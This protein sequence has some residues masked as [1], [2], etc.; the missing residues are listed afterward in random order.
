[1]IKAHP[2]SLICVHSHVTSYTTL[3]DAC[4]GLYPELWVTSGGDMPTYSWFV[5]H[6][7]KSLDD[8]VGGHS[9]CSGGATALA[10][11]GA[12]DDSIQAMGQWSSNTFQIYIRKHP[13][14]LYALIHNKPAF[15]PTSPS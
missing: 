12:N 2:S 9:L 15:G 3:C 1:M 5:S 13:V 8:E 10:L 11:A 14:I 4:F 7:Q 6:L